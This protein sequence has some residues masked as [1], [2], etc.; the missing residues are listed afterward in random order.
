MSRRRSYERDR[1]TLR[2]TKS[3]PTEA[4]MPI[5]RS[6]H[7]VFESLAD[8]SG[9]T[10]FWYTKTSGPSHSHHEDCATHGLRIDTT[11]QVT[12]ETGA[13]AG[14]SGREL[15]AAS[16]GTNPIT[17]IGTISFWPR[18]RQTRTGKRSTETPLSAPCSSLTK[19]C[20]GTVAVSLRRPRSHAETDYLRAVDSLHQAQV[21]RAESATE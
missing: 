1:M 20:R 15:S 3:P 8:P 17:F 7:T 18:Q 16:A 11:F 14:A 10:R 19:W 4:G 6:E 21:S 9:T 5:R 2:F 13:F 12:G